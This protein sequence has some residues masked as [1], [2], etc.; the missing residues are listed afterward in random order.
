MDLALEEELVDLATHCLQNP[1]LDLRDAER[2][3]AGIGR[4]VH[5]E[6][7]E[8]AMEALFFAVRNRVMGEIEKDPAPLRALWNGIS[9]GWRY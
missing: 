7:G 3:I 6:G 5:A 9:D 8:D 4:Q 2:R 1:G